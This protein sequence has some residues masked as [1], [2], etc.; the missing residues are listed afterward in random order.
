MNNSENAKYVDD[1][2]NILFEDKDYDK[3]DKYRE[4]IVPK[5]LYKFMCFT[6][7]MKLN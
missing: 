5:N 6:N 2:L 7:D 3:S 4:S 1:M